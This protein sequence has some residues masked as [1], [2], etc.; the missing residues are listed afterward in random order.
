MKV[1]N[2]SFWG[3]KYI[4]I[5]FQEKRSRHT[6]YVIC[7]YLLY[8]IYTYGTTRR[9]ETLA[10]RKPSRHSFY[11]DSKFL[12]TQLN[13]KWKSLFVLGDTFANKERLGRTRLFE[14]FIQRW[15]SFGDGSDSRL[16]N[17][18][19]IFIPSPFVS[20]QHNE[21]S[22]RHFLEKDRASQIPT[23]A[24]AYSQRSRLQS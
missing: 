16:R 22:I 21:I 17:V 13:H 4:I 12:N 5:Y 8:K 23:A 19:F 15:S 20:Y 14:V 1:Q 2:I 7:I 11:K 24:Q 9:S 6:F 10:D 3:Y 18:F